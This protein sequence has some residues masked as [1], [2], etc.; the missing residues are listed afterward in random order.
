[1]ARRAA[2][3]LYHG[4]GPIVGPPRIRASA[5]GVNRTGDQGLTD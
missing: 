2:G 5:D 1:M 3:T 4:R